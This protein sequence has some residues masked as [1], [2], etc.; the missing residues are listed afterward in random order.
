MPDPLHPQGGHPR[1]HRRG[2]DRRAPRVRDY[3]VKWHT[4]WVRQFGIDGFRCDT[5]KN[6]ELA[7]WKAL[8][9]AGTAALADWK[10]ANP[11]KAIDDA[12]FW[13]TGEV[14][15]H[16]VD[17]DA[18][19]TDGGFDSLINFDFQPPL[20]D[21]VCGAKPALVGQRRRRSTRSTPQVRRGASRR[22]VLRR[23][24]LPLLARHPAL[25]RRASPGTTPARQR[26]AGTALLLAPGRRPG[27]LRRRE[28]PAPRPGR[29][30]PHPGH[31]L[32]HELD[33]HRRLDPGP[34]PRSSATFRKRHAAVGAGTHARLT[35]PAGTYAFTRTLGGRR[36]TRW[37]S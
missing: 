8:K 14:Y 22:P 5:A 27:L 33:H 36:R 20:R 12:P 17:K 10:A 7:R 34:L 13:M 1:R 11:G 32:R 35:S 19:Y 18:Y 3:L 9:T 24:L 23:P 4:D 21:A 15:G 2:R 31:P 25:L 28:R 26:Q 37:W 30:R 16:G 29:Q 6:V